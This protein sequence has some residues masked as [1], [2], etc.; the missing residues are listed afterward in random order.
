[1]PNV[2]VTSADLQAALTLENAQGLEAGH[3]D[4][5]SV[6]YEFLTQDDDRVRPSHQ[7]L[8]GTVWR[9]GDVSAP[10]PPL[11][12]GC[13]C[14][15]KYVAKP[16]SEAA[17]FLPPAESKPT[18]QSKAW[19][20]WLDKEAPTW[21]TLLKTA[22]NT[23]IEDRLPTL[24]LAIQKATNKPMVESR[25]LAR[26]ALATEQ[27][28]A[29][30]PASLKVVKPPI[31][32]APTLP[33]PSPTAVPPLAAVAPPIPPPISTPTP[34]PDDEEATKKRVL[35]AAV[36]AAEARIAA[37]KAAAAIEADAI[38][39]TAAARAA[40]AAI[41][42]NPND[43]LSQDRWAA[44][45]A[46]PKFEPSDG[47]K[48]KPWLSSPAGPGMDKAYA[49]TVTQRGSDGEGNAQRA[50]AAND[51]LEALKRDDVVPSFAFRAA[52][53]KGLFTKGLLNQHHTG[54]SGG[55]LDPQKRDGL[56]KSM[57]GVSS[58]EADDH[59]TYGYLRV[60]GKGSGV[61]NYGDIAVRLKPRVLERTTFTHGDSLD[62]NYHLVNDKNQ[63]QS[64][65]APASP[66]LEPGLQSFNTSG[67]KSV[68]YIEAQ[69]FGKITKDDILRID[70]INKKPTEEQIKMMEAAGI[71]YTVNSGGYNKDLF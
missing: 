35:E 18:T 34:A 15:I 43:Q 33:V 28:G 7:A 63:V 21:E 25:D 49:R 11:D 47:L 71:P 38:I 13:R 30:S 6:W 14:F 10:V 17:K 44:I 52:N 65:L 57:F 66:A 58:N 3:L 27:Q 24:T 12:Y 53:L 16:D 60:S 20:D 41:P 45:N 39:A 31:S 22:M 51:Y 55:M 40:R 32:D 19:G 50:E 46:I 4:S 59:P 61:S 26:M 69:F 5:S 23:P 1:M 62:R 29:K 2:T 67:L 9:V 37:R 36:A 56:E 70:W 68:S 64:P 48:R 42:V 54:T 8:H